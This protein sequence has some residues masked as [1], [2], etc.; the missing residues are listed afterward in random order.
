MKR[1]IVIKL[2]VCGCIMAG[3]TSSQHSEN[4]ADTLQH[5]YP[6]DSTWVESPS[7]D[8]LAVDSARNMPV[9]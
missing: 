1:F 8:S 7:V 9:D 6:E 3:C 2:L 5:S 4:T